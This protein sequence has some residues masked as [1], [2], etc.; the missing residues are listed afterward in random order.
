MNDNRKFQLPEF[1][2]GA[3][4]QTRAASPTQRLLEKTRLSKLPEL[5]RRSACANCGGSLD[6]TD[7]YQT[8]VKLCRACLR[9]YA[10]IGAILETHTAQ[11]IRKIYQGG[12]NE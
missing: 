2:G 3:G 10:K 4:E 5:P 8:T 11:K 9:N 12:A 1:D 7:Q 6:T